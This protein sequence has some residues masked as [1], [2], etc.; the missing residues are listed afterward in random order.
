M[1]DRL[2]L[3]LNSLHVSSTEL[4][5]IIGVSPAMLS[6]I[7]T[8]RTQPSITIVEKL[9]HH[10]PDLRTDWLIFGT[11]PMLQSQDLHNSTAINNQ[12]SL[13]SEES[14]S[15]NVISEHIPHQQAELSQSDIIVDNKPKTVVKV[16]LLYS[17]GSFEEYQK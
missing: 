13:F 14:E 12:V 9:K 6:S 15:I 2:F 17:D 7:K 1:K 5:K 3:F 4:A 16:I 10:Y 11:G 8:G